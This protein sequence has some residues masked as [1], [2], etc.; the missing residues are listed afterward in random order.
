MTETLT[1]FFNRTKLNAENYNVWNFDIQGSEL[2]VFKGSPELLQYADVIYTEVN[3]G[4]VYK[5]CGILSEMDT[6]LDAYGFSRVATEMT[7]YKWGDAVYIK[8]QDLNKAD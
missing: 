1:D 3:S 7:P 5:N 2:N 6:F 8:K 4:E